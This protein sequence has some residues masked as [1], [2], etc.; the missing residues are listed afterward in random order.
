MHKK[1]NFCLVLAL[2]VQILQYANFLALS[3]ISNWQVMTI[4][5]EF[6]FLGMSMFWNPLTDHFA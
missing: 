4:V 1:K 5:V 6:V 2:Q 3:S